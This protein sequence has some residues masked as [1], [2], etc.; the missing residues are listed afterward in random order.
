MKEKISKWF[1]R[2][3]FIYSPMQGRSQAFLI[4]GSKLFSKS[5]LYTQPHTNSDTS[6]ENNW[7]PYIMSA[8]WY[9]PLY[10]Y[11]HYIVKIKLETTC[12]S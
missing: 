1:S 7:P 10:D 3:D 8:I 11:S 4:E 6:W 2:M 12:A 9:P 5:L